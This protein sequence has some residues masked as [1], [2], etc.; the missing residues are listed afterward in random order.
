MTQPSLA[1]EMM[2]S[3]LIS[4]QQQWSYH[5]PNIPAIDVYNE[6]KKIAQANN[7]TGP[8]SSAA[9]RHILPRAATEIP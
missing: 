1:T 8:G 3:Q 7:Y 9:F 2:V 5:P 4:G 6:E